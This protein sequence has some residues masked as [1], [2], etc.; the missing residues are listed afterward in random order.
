MLTRL[1]PKHPH[2]KNLEGSGSQNHA[3]VAEIVTHTN[4]FSELVSVSPG[5]KTDSPA[6]PSTLS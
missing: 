1:A 2:S 4:L 6:S 3:F 5:I